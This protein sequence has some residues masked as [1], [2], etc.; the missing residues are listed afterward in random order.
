MNLI[1]I[2]KDYGKIKKNSTYMR[3]IEMETSCNKEHKIYW[4]LLHAYYAI[5][6]ARYT[7]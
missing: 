3:L 2:L 1:R 5:G 7:N 6:K 4:R